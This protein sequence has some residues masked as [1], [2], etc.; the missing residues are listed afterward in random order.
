M[1]ALRNA[2]LGALF[3]VLPATATAGV[4]D[5][6]G[7]QGFLTDINGNAVEAGAGLGKGE[8]DGLH[9]AVRRGGVRAGD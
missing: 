6:I 5:M 9:G 7:F 2:I 8:L 1:K 4:P 3:L